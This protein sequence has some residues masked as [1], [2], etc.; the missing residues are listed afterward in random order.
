M[1]SIVYPY[2]VAPACT[3]LYLVLESYTELFGWKCLSPEGPKINCLGNVP[4]N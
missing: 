1:G 4:L 2:G 3:L